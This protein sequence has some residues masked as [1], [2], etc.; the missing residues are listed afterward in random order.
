VALAA[1][2]VL[3]VAGLA[4]FGAM[5]LP[6]VDGSDATTW[7][8]WSASDIAQAVVALLCVAIAVPALFT[9]AR[10][11]PLLLAAA[12]GLLEGVTNWWSVPGLASG[13]IVAGIA[14]IVAF[15]AGVVAA[16]AWPGVRGRDAGGVL[17]VLRLCGALLAVV[18][19]AAMAA[20]LT[21]APSSWGSG[22]IL[23]SNLSIVAPCALFALAMVL[24]RARVVAYL[25][26]AAGAAA[27]G[28]FVVSLL[29][30]AAL[31]YADVRGKELVAATGAVIAL[32]G[33]AL[34]AAGWPKPRPRA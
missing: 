31:P 16:S 18:G 6:F 13:P 22:R 26:L 11:M 3:P 15:A 30:I 29:E 9:R 19:A 34:A 25:L 1:T 4:A 17:T 20:G 21:K 7:E 10:V 23:T 2:L 12:G 24:A 8:T 5:F 27:T 28:F 32:A 33:G 14:G